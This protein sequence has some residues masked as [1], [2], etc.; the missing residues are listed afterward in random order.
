[1]KKKIWII[2]SSG[3]GKSCFSEQLSWRLGY[4]N[5]CLDD[6][7]WVSCWQKREAAAFVKGVSDLI[8]E[9]SWI[10]EGVYSQISA[11]LLGEV[12]SVIWLDPPLY[13]LIYRVAKRSIINILLKREICNGNRETFRNLFS[14]QSILLFLLKSHRSNRKEYVKYCDYLMHNRPEV[15]VYRIKEHTQTF[16]NQLVANE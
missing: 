15:V 16:I 12:D 10:I 7:F 4:K 3:S 1:M 2:G 13:K 8:K 9:D 11:D 14:R 6:L 5:H